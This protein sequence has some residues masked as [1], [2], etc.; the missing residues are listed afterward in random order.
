MSSLILAE[1]LS[2]EQY[3][4]LAYRYLNL[5]SR[6]KVW[7]GDVPSD[8]F[9]ERKANLTRGNVKQWLEQEA[10]TL[11]DEILLKGSFGA[12]QIFLKSRGHPAEVDLDC[13]VVHAEEMKANAVVVDA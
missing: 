5:K 4:G 11:V 1:A 8:Y 9:I 13:Q 10:Q 6:A 2:E 3:Q 7:W 12:P